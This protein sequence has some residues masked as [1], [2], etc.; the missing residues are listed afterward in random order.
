MI[1]RI[2]P[3]GKFFLRRKFFQKTLTNVAGGL[4]LKPGGA[5]RLCCCIY[6]YYNI[7][8]E[9]KAPEFPSDIEELLNSVWETYGD[10]DGNE[11]EA[12]SHSEK[13]WKEARVN[14]DEDERGNA[15]ISP[16]TMKAFYRSIYSGDI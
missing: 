10:K 16:K 3:K 1:F 8:K 13:P 2:L 12:L 11:L 6:F 15:I 7:K 4:I 5:K 9:E 14:L